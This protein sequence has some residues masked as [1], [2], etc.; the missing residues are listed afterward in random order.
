MQFTREQI[1]QIIQ[2]E[3]DFVMEAYRKPKMTKKAIR[4]FSRRSGYTAEKLMDRLKNAKIS[5]GKLTGTFKG[6]KLTFEKEAT[7]N[8]VLVGVPEDPGT[9]NEVAKEVMDLAP[10]EDIVISQNG[11]DYV[12]NFMKGGEPVDGA[13]VQIDGDYGNIHIGMSDDRR[14]FGPL[15]YDIAMQFLTDYLD[16][17]MIPSVLAGHETSDAAASIW[18]YYYD[19]RMDVDSFPVLQN[20]IED[21]YYDEFDDYEIETLQ[22]L[23]EYLKS[24]YE[25]E[26]DDIIGEL[27]RRRN[28]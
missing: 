22:E 3:I 2:E 28:Q 11:D 27:K 9:L 15:I 23:P 1:T 10:D 26:G 6:E 16:K 25:W 18:K 20:R 4:T 7:G 5:G 8:Y 17:T 12:I 24:G 19:R 13:L 21:G 14:G